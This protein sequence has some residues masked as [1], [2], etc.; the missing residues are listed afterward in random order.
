MKMAR[1]VIS[2]RSKNWPSRLTPSLTS[3]WHRSVLKSP[4]PNLTSLSW[5]K[6]PS[7]VPQVFSALTPTE[8]QPYFHWRQSILLQ[9]S[10]LTTLNNPS[11]SGSSPRTRMPSL[12]NKLCNQCTRNSTSSTLTTWRMA[13]YVRC[14]LAAKSWS[15]QATLHILCSGQAL[16][17]GSFS[18]MS[19]IW[20]I[21][22]SST[23]V[24][25]S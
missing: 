24:R 14:K 13:S 1:A 4:Q 2:N 12:T 8:Q 7:R 15:A 6:T 9:A 18:L 19:L 16:T 11:R 3:I 10:I 21:W 23:L 17:I 20:R 22:S 25:R 5:V